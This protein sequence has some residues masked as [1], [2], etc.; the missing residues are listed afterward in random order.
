MK[1]KEG[2][3]RLENWEAL[4]QEDSDEQNDDSETVEST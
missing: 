3:W 1:N 2:V 4:T